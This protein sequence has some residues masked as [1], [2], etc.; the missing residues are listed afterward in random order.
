MQNLQDTPA[1]EVSAAAFCAPVEQ[2]GRVFSTQHKHN[3]SFDADF[4]VPSRQT[5]LIN[6]LSCLCG[7]IRI[8][9][10]SAHTECLEL[11]GAK[12]F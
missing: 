1:C 9:K 5:V 2:H 12:L 4:Q 8:S 6:S 3:A 10:K 7:P 11:A